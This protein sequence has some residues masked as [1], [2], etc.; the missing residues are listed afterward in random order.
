MRKYQ[1]IKCTHA[2]VLLAIIAFC[3]FAWW[4]LSFIEGKYDYW[5]FEEKEDSPKWYGFFIAHH[6]SQI[7]KSFLLWGIAR[8]YLHK[9]ISTVFLGML[10]FDAWRLISYLLFRWEFPMWTVALVFLCFLLTIYYSGKV[11]FVKSLFF[12]PVYTF[13]RSPQD[14]STDRGNTREPQLLFAIR[15]HAHFF[16]RRV[17][18]A[19]HRRIDLWRSK[20]LRRK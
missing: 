7:V 3:I 14:G 2:L 19:V 1:T 20:V 8:R 16:Y 6:V 9:L 18:N 12:L 11:H 13:R 5:L 17:L 10:I 4:P 15:Y